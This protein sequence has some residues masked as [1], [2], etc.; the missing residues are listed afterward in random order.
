[1][2]CAGFLLEKFQPDSQEN[3]L[4]E[5][6][7]LGRSQ[8][9][10]KKELLELISSISKTLEEQTLPPLSPITLLSENSLFFAASYL[11]IMAKGHICVP[12][13]T[14][15]SQKYYQHVQ[16]ITE[17]PLTL[18]SN[19]Q[20]ETNTY[21]ELFSKTIQEKDLDPSQN[22]VTF[23]KVDPSDTAL[24]I[25]TS[26]ST[27]DPKGVELSH[28][29]IVANTES[30]IESLSIDSSDVQEIVLPF[31]YSFGL[32]LLNTH[33]RANAKIVINNEFMFPET[34]LEDIEKYKVTSFSG[35][36][37][38]YQFLLKRSHFLKTEMPSLKKL[39]QAGGKLL[40][41]T[42]L[43]MREAFPDK[44]LFIMYGA[45][46]ATARLTCFSLTKNPSKLG[47]IGTPIANVESKIVDSS[48]SE[49]ENGLD[50]KILVKGPNIMK[51]Y[52]K[53]QDLTNKA[54]VGDWFITGDIGHKDQDGHIT[55]SGREKSFIKSAGYRVSPY[56]V[57]DVL[58][59]HPGILE[60]AVVG[61][62]DRLL[63][64]AIKAYIVLRPGEEL[65][66]SE[67]L[68]SLQ[69]KLPNHKVPTKIQFLDGLPKKSNGKLDREA[70]KRMQ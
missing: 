60:C 20:K 47:T 5:I 4:D 48:F 58:S 17:S 56:E 53:D 66:N 21:I 1:M 61:I 34:V 26:G 55:I 19:L 39:T 43:K 68:G 12:L 44:E 67:I 18:V 30:I 27:G 9:A 6:F 41:K 28:G 38:S 37:S 7:L 3:N 11:A 15:A 36:P 25:F 50:G 31:F 52:Y 16:R 23:K 64:E 46:E 42:A 8:P 69:E 22:N 62:P 49:L 32:S 51:G 35:V 33:L 59:D 63:G 24:I 29:N 2:N 40:D 14:K 65:S 54:F 57:E 70:L 45:T 13:D 10:S